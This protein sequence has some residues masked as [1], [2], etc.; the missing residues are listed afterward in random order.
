MADNYINLTLDNLEDE[1]LCCA[2]SDK[3]HQVGVDLKKEWLKDRLKEGHVFRKLDQK[4]KVFIEYA[5]LE[6]AWVPIVGENYMYIYCLWV[7]GSFKGHGHANE[8]LE[9]CIKDAKQKGKS[10]ICILS[11]KKKMPFLS[12]PQYL[13]YKGFKVCDTAEP[14]FE[15][16]YLSFD[17]QSE[18]PKFKS[19]A[20]T[21]EI[22]DNG[23]VFY[24][25]NQ[26]PYTVK[27]VSIIAN[28][29]EEN[30]FD[31]T[32]RHLTSVEIAKNAPTPFTTYSVYYNGKF[33]TNEILSEKKF[34]KIFLI[35][36]NNMNKK[37][38]QSIEDYINNQPDETRR[39]LEYIRS[40]IL[41]AVPD[42]IEIFNYDIPAFALTTGGKREQQVMIAGYK[43]HIGFYPHPTVIEHFSDEL[44]EYKIGKGS[45]QFPINKPLPK[46]LIIRMVKYRNGLIDELN[47][48]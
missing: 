5:P 22:S 28:L 44:K 15:L 23:F 11:S 33:V 34:E 40:F 36:D 17:E 30:G 25:T 21:G 16:L 48:Y 47:Q 43:K 38:F 13:K 41:E 24:Y 8:L 26:C 2:I 14:Y 19:Q 18:K 45:V 6:K 39:A 10:G 29:A 46:E 27:Y 7:S 31:V 20:K 3:K 4:G 42:A 32:I 37:P 9:G 35:G 1:H 12:D